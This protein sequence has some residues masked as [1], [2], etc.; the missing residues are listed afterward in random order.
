MDPG[1]AVAA[2]PHAV[3][4][5]ASTT[6]KTG[7]VREKNVILE[8]HFIYFLESVLLLAEQPTP[9]LRPSRVSRNRVSCCSR[10]S[11]MQL[12]QKSLDFSVRQ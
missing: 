8:P 11:K 1:T 9:H 3:T 4:A 5:K 10:F 2:P 7:V 12:E 6:R